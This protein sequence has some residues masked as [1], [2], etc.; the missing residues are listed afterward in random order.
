M[1]E[2]EKLASTNPD[3][4]ISDLFNAIS[5]GNFPSWTFYI[6]V[7]TFE[8]AERFQFNPFDL[9]KVKTNIYILVTLSSDRFCHRVACW[10]LLWANINLNNG[11]VLTSCL[12]HFKIGINSCISI[13]VWPHK[14]YPL[15]PVGKIVLNRNPSNYFAEVEQMAFDPSNMPRG[16]EPSP[17]KMLQVTTTY[18]QK[19]KKMNKHSWD[20]VYMVI[21]WPCLNR[22][23]SQ[24]FYLF[25]HLFNKHQ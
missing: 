6:Q 24:S 21:H 18:P 19:E 11:W 17:D 23:F 1:E 4:S 20:I 3:Y 8:Q 14:D 12:T 9:T 10:I 22:E 5:N 13:K 25:I 7:M 15:I 2:A 16:I